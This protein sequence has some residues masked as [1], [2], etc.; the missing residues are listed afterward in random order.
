M[1]F[2]AKCISCVMSVKFLLGFNGC[3]VELFISVNVCG[4]ES[5]WVCCLLSV[6]A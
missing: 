5:V 1:V 6:L 2:F 3:L 4:G